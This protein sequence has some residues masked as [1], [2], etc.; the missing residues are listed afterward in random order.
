MRN[1]DRFIPGEEIKDVAQWQF[2][3][4]ETAAQ[5]LQAQV[6]EREAQQQRAQYDAQCQQSYQEGFTAGV[7]H[8]RQ[9]AQ[10]ALQEQM[11]AAM[12]R[13]TQEAAQR[14]AGLFRQAE[15]Q[16]QEVEQTLAQGTLELAC[17]LARQVVRRELT[18]DTQAVL[19][20]L[21]EALGLLE[22]QHTAAQVRLHPSDLEAL[23]KL[24]QADLGAGALHLRADES[25]QPGDCVVESAGMVVDGTVSK[26]WQHAVATLGLTSR[27]EQADDRV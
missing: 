23:G 4:I 27:W 10:Q 20:V 25:L 17:E 26:R 1:D 24:I 7:E 9:M 13:Q 14:F 15:Q 21:K 19:P 3:A 16:L 8:E 12:E 18:V 11:Q 22:L 5:L 2:A 6:R